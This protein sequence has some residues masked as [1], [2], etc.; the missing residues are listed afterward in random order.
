MHKCQTTTEFDAETYLKMELEISRRGVQFLALESLCSPSYEG[1]KVH[2]SHSTIVPYILK[3]LTSSFEGQRSFTRTH[4]DYICKP[5]PDPPLIKKNTFRIL[6]R[7][8]LLPV[9]LY[10]KLN[11]TSQNRLA[12]KARHDEEE[13]EEPPRFRHTPCLHCAQRQT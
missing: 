2:V 12:S 5:A 13:E 3:L 4:Q 10:G 6:C 1:L 9:F 11:Y 8:V 7:S